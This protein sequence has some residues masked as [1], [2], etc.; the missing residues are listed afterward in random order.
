M[1]IENTTNEQL[2]ELWHKQARSMSFYAAAEGQAWYSERTARDIC[3]A[4]FRK[5]N[6]ELKRREIPRPQGDYL[7]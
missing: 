7:C 6:E 5:I 4:E 3:G 1:S 2:I